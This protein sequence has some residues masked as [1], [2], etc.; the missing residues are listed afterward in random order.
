MF[1]RVLMQLH[2][3]LKFTLAIHPNSLRLIRTVTPWTM[4][5][6]LP[7]VISP[8]LVLVCSRLFIPGWAVRGEEEHVAGLD[9]RA[10][11]AIA[12]AGRAIVAV[13]GAAGARVAV[14]GKEKTGGAS[15]E[16][17]GGAG[18]VNRHQHLHHHHHNKNQ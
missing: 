8:V 11:V 10:R 13:A 1:I 15:K 4:Q 3:V 9:E 6:R 5:V 18:A 16:K 7:R 14:A 17:T 12:G 2:R